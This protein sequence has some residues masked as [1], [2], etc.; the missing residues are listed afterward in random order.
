[1][2][3]LGNFLSNIFVPTNTNV[4][5][6]ININVP[7][8]GAQLQGGV[9]TTNIIGSPVNDINHV[10]NQILSNPIQ[11][12]IP[13]DI[14]AIK[15]EAE[16][17]SLPED[18]QHE[19]STAYPL[20]VIPTSETTGSDSRPEE[21]SNLEPDPQPEVSAS[22]PKEA[23]ALDENPTFEPVL[24]QQGQWV[25]QPLTPEEAVLPDPNTPY[26]LYVSAQ[27]TVQA[28][29]ATA[30]QEAQKELDALEKE[31][32]FS[33]ETIRE[34]KRQLPS[35]KE[36]GESLKNGTNVGGWITNAVGVLSDPQLYF[37]QNLATYDAAV[38]S[39]NQQI[40][41]NNA[42]LQEWI[43]EGKRHKVA[44]DELLKEFDPT[45][46]NSTQYKAFTK[47]VIDE[48]NVHGQTIGKILAEYYPA[49]PD[50][51]DYPLTLSEKFNHLF[52]V[53]PKY[54]TDAKKLGH[55][56]AL[57]LSL[58]KIDALTTCGKV[59]QSLNVGAT[60]GGI[61]VDIIENW[62]EIAH[63]FTVDGDLKSRFSQ[64]TWDTINTDL[65][66]GVILG[67]DVVASA[68]LTPAGGLIVGLS[69]HGI[70]ALLKTAYY[71]HEYG[72]QIDFEKTLLENLKLGNHEDFVLK[73]DQESSTD[74]EA[75]LKGYVQDVM[76]L[77]YAQEILLKGSVQEVLLQGKVN[78]VTNLDDHVEISP[79]SENGNLDATNFIVNCGSN[80][81]VNSANGNATIINSGNDSSVFA[82][83]GGNNLIYNDGA[84][85]VNIS[86]G[87][88]GNNTIT[89]VDSQH[90]TI[91][92]SGTI[93]LS[94]S[95]NVYLD[96]GSYSTKIYGFDFLSDTLEVFNPSSIRETVGNDLVVNNLVS[97]VTLVGCASIPSELFNIVGMP[98]AQEVE[99]W[100]PVK[101]IENSNSR[102]S[103]Q[104]DTG[105]GWFGE[106]KKDSIVNNGYDVTI[107]A[108]EDKDTVIAHDKALIFAGNENDKIIF[109]SEYD[110]SAT[111][112]G[113]N[114]DDTITLVHGMKVLVNGGADKDTITD[115]SKGFN[116]TLNGGS[117]S[118]L[119][120][121]K[122]DD[123]VI[124]GGA[125]SD[126]IKS[127]GDFASIYA[128]DGDKIYL[129]GGEKSTVTISDGDN[130]IY[131]DKNSDRNT[132]V[133]TTDSSN[134]TISGL[135]KNSTLEF[136]DHFTRETV[137]G[138][139][140]FKTSNGST[141]LIYSSND[142]NLLGTEE[143]TPEWS[144]NGNVATYG[145]NRNTI[146]TLTNVK[147]TNSISVDGMTVTLKAA[148]LNKKTV[149]ISDNDY[150]LKLAD[151]VK[152][153]VKTAASWSKVSSGKATYTFASTTTGY[154]LKD[155]KI[156]YTKAV[157][158]K[159]FT[160]SGI[161]STSGIK[162][163]GMT[164]TL[165]AANLNKK[166]VS[167]SD[168]DYTLKLADDVSNPVK[169]KAGWIKDSKNKAT[170]VSASTTAG[171]TLKNNVIK[172]TKA[173]KA[174]ELVTLNGIA[175]T[176]ENPE[177][178]VVT[179]KAKNFSKE[180]SITS[181]SGQ[182]IFEVESGQYKGKTLTSS[183][184]VDTI[185]SSGKNL[186]INSNA[187]DDEIT[188]TGK[189]SSVYSGSGDDN[190]WIS[191]GIAHGGSGN[192]VI[193]AMSGK[194][195]LWGDAGDD[196]LYG[197]SGCDVFIYK[198]NE[199]IDTIFDYDYENGD[200][201]QILK[202]DGSSSG[203]FTKATFSDGELK[204]AINGG[205]QVTFEDVSA[206]DKFNINGKTYKISDKT[207]K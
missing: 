106:S 149:S 47:A 52:G 58:Q 43:D 41:Q 81:T 145:T 99:L 74:T 50:I 84:D 196:L 143:T 46:A 147:N 54:A 192:D 205:G 97:N 79:N 24:K 9:E 91:S 129:L 32:L 83:R 60:L 160:L 77:G 195:S 1:M 26:K 27:E 176:L 123:N 35:P 87:W 103:I 175:E 3:D 29:Y 166:T 102:V 164:V 96:P 109:D 40:L 157:A 65:I 173:T 184:S 201:L 59:L 13:I 190:I 114:G 186:V 33:S 72:D 49:A 117:D 112:N 156:T 187:G 110:S 15:R 165:K 153:P 206:G 154:S 67:I 56:K 138:N 36:W 19:N 93:S 71:K 127:F 122:S 39:T 8:P 151:D 10:T 11:T 131:N 4:P 179:L 22:D 128:S 61:G 42:I 75:Y 150:T 185:N 73:Q 142:F 7:V 141:T 121:S 202:S 180:L 136:V 82:G 183:N 162:V 198:P 203:S 101:T 70:G 169:A 137:D 116:N 28:E 2:F 170:Y 194:N 88:G 177:D 104:G 133:V 207:L 86:G 31:G 45:A 34:I 159:S 6:N 126:T 199:G 152:A 111:L 108:G 5:T 140:V 135:T 125:G 55:I 148:N 120:I 163:D 18:T 37:S 181:N 188:S 158:P 178:D 155:N 89:V 130:F 118:D 132:F 76:L 94:S 44:V 95:K 20:P 53:D 25:S 134:N 167:I 92:T 23:G 115:T 100:E 161:K 146:F 69:L 113:E 30:Y 17:N 51:D 38:T 14:N 107:S 64:K 193:V 168:N 90:V 48:G 172:Y 119:I 62:D 182:Y 174:T 139:P 144:L 57:R 12:D 16:T 124:D 105:G 63:A 171:Y 80:T 204:L 85:S 21:S 191:D 200:M 98:Q 78:Y 66:D 68:T 189:N 197:G